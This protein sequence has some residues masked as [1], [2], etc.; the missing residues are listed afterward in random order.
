MQPVTTGRAGSKS[1][2]PGPARPSFPSAPS[3]PGIRRL[4]VGG[5]SGGGGD[6]RPIRAQAVV[7]IVILLVLLAIPVYLLRRP[8]SHP[9]DAEAAAS[10]KTAFSA[11][12]PALMFE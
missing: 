5:S 2:M 1:R 4:G 3:E 10:A 9:E 8:S 11:S 6:D 7:A 12:V